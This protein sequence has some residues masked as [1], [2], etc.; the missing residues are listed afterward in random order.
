MANTEL[1]KVYDNGNVLE[2]RFR[3]NITELRSYRKYNNLVFFYQNN[4][5]L[6]WKDTICSLS[7]VI[8]YH[9]NIYVN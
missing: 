8:K 7:Q 9:F 3:R 2:Q 6:K 1:L 4:L 5:F